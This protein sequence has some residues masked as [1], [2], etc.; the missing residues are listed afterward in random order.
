MTPHTAAAAAEEKKTNKLIFKQQ[1]VCVF[2]NKE[3]NNNG[4][5][6]CISS[7]CSFEV[8]FTHVFVSHWN[9]YMQKKRKKFYK[10]NKVNK[11]EI[12]IILE[13]YKC[14]RARPSQ[15]CVRVKC[16]YPFDSTERKKRFFSENF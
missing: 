1:P 12:T 6:L 15:Q 9:C 14:K 2:D 7:V 11:T 16:T 3:M 8:L 4:M 10:E 13:N 5:P